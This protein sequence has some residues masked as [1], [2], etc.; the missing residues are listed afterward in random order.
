MDFIKLIEVR[1][2]LGAGTRGASLGVDAL[3]TAC[4]DKGSDYFIRFDI[5]E[6][7]TENDAL[8]EPTPY[9]HAKYIDAV[10]KVERRTCDA[11]RDAIEDGYFPLILAG[12]HSTAAGS[13]A[14][15]KLAYPN[16]RIGA[17]WIDAHA[18]LHS[19]Y[20]SPSG[21]IHGMPL[22]I[23]TGEDNKQS[24]KNT[25]H[26]DT[27]KWWNKLK[28]VGGDGQ[29]ILPND[30]VFVAVRDVEEEERFLMN[31]YGIR[32]FPTAEVRNK[33]VEQIVEEVLDKLKDCDLI[34]ISFDVDSLDPNI[35]EG[36]GTPVEN[37]LSVEQAKQLN[38]LLISNDKVCAW[39]MVEVNPTLDR[40]N[41]MAEEA[42]DILEYVTDI[43]AESRENSTRLKLDTQHPR[44]PAKLEG[45]FRTIAE[46]IMEEEE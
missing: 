7:E 8:F 26:D 14:G 19:P 9:E 18:D 10:Y 22:A 15:I 11:V 28:H 1:S 40:E 4:L 25:P 35:S 3:K 12:D 16:K 21:N 43:L 41:A 32:N 37:G 2:E 33:G 44:N 38:S 13:I 39:E 42:F 27:V 46:E 17:I 34:Y 29:N 30:I 6:V 5:A 45:Y 24:R 20:T 23:A 31:K 36:T